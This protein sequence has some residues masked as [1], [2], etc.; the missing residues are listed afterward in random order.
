[1]SLSLWRKRISQPQGGLPV[2]YAASIPIL[3]AC[4]STDFDLT[5][6]ACFSASSHAHSVSSSTLSLP[7]GVQAPQ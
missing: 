7:A 5:T 2:K 6:G 3:Q 1:M 4:F